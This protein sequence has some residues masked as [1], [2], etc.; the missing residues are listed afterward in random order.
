MHKSM[1]TAWNNESAPTL[2]SKLTK[3]KYQLPMHV[4]K[5]VRW[6]NHQEARNKNQRAERSMPELLT[7]QVSNS[8]AC[9]DGAPSYPVGQYIKILDKANRQDLLKA[10]HI[11]LKDEGER[12]NRDIGT[13]VPYCWIAMLKL[14]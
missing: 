7:G 14:L 8:R 6:G 5:S 2:R 9:L 11:Q 12:V 3:V 13:A 4:W 1:S 10:M